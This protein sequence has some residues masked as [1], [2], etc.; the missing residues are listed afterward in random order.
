M[1]NPLPSIHQ[2]RCFSGC[3]A[4]RRADA[5]AGGGRLSDP[6]KAFQVSARTAATRRSKSP[7]RSRRGTTSTASSSV[8]RDR[9]SLGAPDLPHGKV[10]YDETFRKDVE[11]YRDVLRVAL[12]VERAD[13][14]FS[15]SW[16]AGLCRCRAVLPRSRAPSRSAS[17]ASAARPVS[18]SLPRARYRRRGFRCCWYADCNRL[19]M[20]PRSA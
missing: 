16:V 18:A 19:E 13:G 11:T 12:P 17:A 9:A 6:D 8:Q 3:V 15:L 7:S 1:R 4:V 5:C 10:K 14:A 2:V 20:A